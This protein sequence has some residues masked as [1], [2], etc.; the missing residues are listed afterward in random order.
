MVYELMQ[1]KIKKSFI[2]YMV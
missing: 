2:N 1:Y